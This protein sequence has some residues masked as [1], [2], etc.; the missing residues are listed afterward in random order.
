MTEPSVLFCPIR[1]ESV[2]ALPEELVRQRMLSYLIEQRGFPASLIAVEKSLK[3]LPHLS[4]ADRRQVPDRRADIICFAKGIKGQ[5]TLYPL[6]IIECK[7]VKLN[8]RTISQVLGYNH[9][10]R[11][12]FVAIVNQEEL[13]M[14]WYDQTAQSYAFTN[15]IASYSQLIKSIVG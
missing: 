13:R 3:Q 12:C 5:S 6:L 14:G 15:D 9:F 4:A 2:A 1:K 7:A 8:S 11:A 10:V